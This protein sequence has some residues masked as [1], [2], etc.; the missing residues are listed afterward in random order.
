MAYVYSR[1]EILW[2][3][4]KIEFHIGT[5]ENCKTDADQ[6]PSLNGFNLYLQEIWLLLKE[7]GT[8]ALSASH[9]W[10]TCG[11]GGFLRKYWKFS[12]VEMQTGPL[13]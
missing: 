3:V 13:P 7:I 12:E 6:Y 1:H 11:L 8:G 5:E 10:V 9:A 4:C 2:R